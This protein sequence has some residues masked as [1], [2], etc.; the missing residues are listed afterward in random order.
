MMKKILL[1]L[2][3][4]LSLFSVPA[5]ANQSPTI[6]IIDSGVV[7]TLFTNIVGEYCVV[8]FFSC[9]NGKSTME[10]TGA[11]NLPVSTNA[12]LTHGTEMASIINKIN[13]AVNILPIRIVGLTST[14]LP[15]IYTNQSVKLALDWIVANRVRYNIKVVNISQGRIFA[16]CA[17]PDGL[18]ADVA[19]L[20]ANGTTVVA[21]TGNNADRTAMM[22]PACLPDVVSV[23]ATDNPDPGT[24]GK[25]WDPTAIPKIATYSNG[26]AQTTYYTN[27]RYYALQPNGTTKF[28]VG[29]S[30]ASA[31]LSAWISNHSTITTSVASNQWLTGKYVFIN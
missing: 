4:G 27:G 24:T 6:A 21:A 18:A 30:C 28:T 16:G 9:P 22:S 1:A 8:E 13:P 29:T 7:D 25:A 23:G 2:T 19:T 11:A 20:K 5:H 12:T 31:A 15:A 26:N 14:N 10:G 3:L 17:V